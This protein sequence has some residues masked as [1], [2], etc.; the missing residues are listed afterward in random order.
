MTSDE[1]L[2]DISHMLA[3]A[4]Q[5][6]GALVTELS[7]GVEYEAQMARERI[8]RDGIDANLQAIRIGEYFRRMTEFNILQ[9]V[10]Q[11]VMSRIQDQPNADDLISPDQDQSDG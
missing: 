4:L 2:R 11:A 8:R 9:R 10:H 1:K 3:D 6:R 5:S 7:E